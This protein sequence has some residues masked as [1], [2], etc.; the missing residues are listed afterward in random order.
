[1]FSNSCLVFNLKYYKFVV[2]DVHTLLFSVRK[3]RLHV[4]ACPSAHC[5]T[6]T[7]EEILIAFNAGG[8]YRSLPTYSSILN[9]TKNENG[10][11]IWRST[12]VPDRVANVI[13]EKKTLQKIIIIK[14]MYNKY[15]SSPKIFRPRRYVKLS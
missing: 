13:S 2:L 9:W 12:G 15:I 10:H 7:T 6:G 3:I 11:V 5:K 1:M 8:F 14:K 4:S